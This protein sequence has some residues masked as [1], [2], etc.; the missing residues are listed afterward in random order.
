[1]LIVDSVRKTYGETHALASLSLQAHP[2]EILGIVGANGAGKSTLVKLLAGE[3]REDGGTITHNDLVLSLERRRELVAVVHQ[4]PQLFPNLTVAANLMVGWGGIAKPRPTPEVE[5]LL[6]HLHIGD[7]ANE[8]LENTSIAVWQLTEIARALLRSAEV[9]VFDEPNSA[10]TKDESQEMFEHM[11]RLRDAGKLV[12]LVSHRLAEVSEICERVVAIRDGSVVGAM[13]G[14]EITTENLASILTSQGLGGA[15]SPAIAA[16]LVASDAPPVA[17]GTGAPGGSGDGP[18]PGRIAEMQIDAANLSICGIRGHVVAVTGPEG[19]GGR[20]L[21]RSAPL[22]GETGRVRRAY[23]PADRRQCLFFNMSVAA[24]IASRLNRRELP[25]RRQ[26]ITRRLLA[27]AADSYIEDFRIKA[28][29][30][31]VIVGSLSGGNQQK[32]A[33]ACALAV[34]P[35]LLIVEE[36][37]RGVDIATKIQ[38]HDILGSFAR[39]GGAVVMF[40]NELEDAVG[41]ADRLFVVDDQVV[42]GCLDVDKSSD[43]EAL[44]ILVNQKLGKQVNAA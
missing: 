44:T 24:N 37:T 27:E 22:V 23:I 41:C 34:H 39:S 17:E 33:L 7:Q 40:V 19:G 11:R 15:A 14:R 36:P 28:A 5:E 35:D 20:E 10:L 3:E 1:M 42:Q 25:S 4:E 18:L 30:P 21:V 43:L 16:P 26:L 13:F 6:Q 8:L 29:H 32:V 38:I 2:R 31:G 9:F 12:I